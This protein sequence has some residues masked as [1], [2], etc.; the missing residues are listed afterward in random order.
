MSGTRKTMATLQALAVAALCIGCG[1]GGGGSDAA[2][3]SG[4]TPQPASTTPT[5]DSRPI[6]AAREVLPVSVK[7]STTKLARVLEA[8]SP[9]VSFRLSAQNDVGPLLGK[10]IYIVVET[11]DANLF[12]PTPAVS[13][14]YEPPTADI[15]LKGA[16]NTWTLGRHTGELRVYACTDPACSV[17]LR[18]SPVRIPFDFNVIKGLGVSQEQVGFSPQKRGAPRPSVDVAVTLP[19]GAT[20]WSISPHGLGDVVQKVGNVLRISPNTDQPPGMYTHT[21]FISASAL[22]PWDTGTITRTYSKRL[23]V[24]YNITQ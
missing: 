18:D 12:Q 21:I 23:F 22:E 4:T 14:S 24:D 11:G 8:G 2:D 13:I 17:Q 6:I 9:D 1:G 19:E 20:D 3:A 15:T 7:S 16:V 5:P 10:T